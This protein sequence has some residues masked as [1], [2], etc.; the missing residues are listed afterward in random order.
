MQVDSKLVSEL[1][2]VM[3]L[4]FNEEE[5]Q[6]LVDEVN[7]TLR[8]FETFYEVD[9]SNVEGTHHGVSGKASFREDKPVQNKEEVEAML[10]QAPASKDTLIEVPA[11]LDNGEGGA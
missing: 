7:G 9:T 4:S 11:V 5:L 1:S 2:T 8:I 3:K 6:E 10:K